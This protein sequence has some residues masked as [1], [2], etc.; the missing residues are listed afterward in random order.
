MIYE[1]LLTCVLPP[2]LLPPLSLSP[3][4]PSALRNYCGTSAAGAVLLQSTIARAP[5]HAVFI[6]LWWPFFPISHSLYALTHEK[7]SFY[8]SVVLS[9]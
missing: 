9:T 6:C 5:A 4:L 2:S 1:A 7:P 3:F 8:Q